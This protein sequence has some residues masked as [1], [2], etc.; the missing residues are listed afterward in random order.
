MSESWVDKYRPGKLK[1]VIG[2]S[3]ALRVMLE[4]A[5]S[6]KIGKPKKTTILIYGAAGVGKTV[7]AAALA[8]EFGWDLI[9]LNASDKRTLEV[10]QQV[11]GTAATTGTLF[12]GAG[13]KRLV[14]LDEADNVYGT[15]DRGGYRAIEELIEETRNPV[16]LIA[17]D[18]YAIPWKIRGACLAINFRRLTQDMVRGALE[19]MCRAEGIEAEP[20]AL[21]AIAEGAGGDLRSAINDLQTLAMGRKQLNMKDVVLHRRD[22][23]ANIFDVLKQL[24]YTKRAKEARE[25]LRALDQTPD[26]ALAWINENIPRML[27]NPADLA[28]AYDAISRADIFLGRAR[29]R[30]AYGLWGYAGDLMSAGVALSREGELKFVHFQPPSAGKYFGMTKAARAVRDGAAKKVAIRCH[31]SSRVARKHFLPYLHLIFKHDRKAASLIATELELSDAEV[32]YLKSVRL[33]GRLSREDSR[34]A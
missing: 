21:K 9:E 17:N 16:V 24:V 28:R 27:T 34:E 26:D 3:Q 20:L 32:D 31:T 6:W 18:Q 23:E 15:A 1:E 10:I 7:A 14:V 12:A 30:Q 33:P 25:L 11:A 5:E 29:R 4:W 13:G 19:R 8:R 22:R 2:Q